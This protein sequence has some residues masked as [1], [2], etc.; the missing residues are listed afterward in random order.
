MLHDLVRFMV[1]PE[2][3]TTA[4]ATGGFRLMSDMERPLLADTVEKVF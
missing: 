2:R 3:E 1:A 4:Y